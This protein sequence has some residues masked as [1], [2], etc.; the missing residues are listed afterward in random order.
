MPRTFSYKDASKLNHKMASKYNSC[1]FDTETFVISNGWEKNWVNL[2]KVELMEIPWMKEAIE[3]ADAKLFIDDCLGFTINSVTEAGGISYNSDGLMY[4]AK[5]IKRPSRFLLRFYYRDQ[6]G[7]W[8][9][10]I[11][12]DRDIRCAT[13]SA[14]FGT[15]SDGFRVFSDGEKK[16]FYTKDGKECL[17]NRI[18]YDD[19]YYC[20]CC[21][22]EWDYDDDYDE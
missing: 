22:P 9:P 2:T 11:N 6:E 18:V 8:K 19:G 13:V 20:S 10:D 17:A 5:N 21:C 3:V 16:Y 4:I 14:N 15:L 7:L 12:G 1:Y